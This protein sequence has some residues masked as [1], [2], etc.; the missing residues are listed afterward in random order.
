VKHEIYA[1]AAKSHID[2]I[3]FSHVSRPRVL[4]PSFTYQRNM[5]EVFRGG[6]GSF[7]VYLMVEAL[8]KVCAGGS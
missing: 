1:R 2:V 5:N 7:A 4:H 6:L 8:L 3:R